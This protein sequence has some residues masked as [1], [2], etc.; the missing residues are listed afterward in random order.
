M[1]TLCIELLCLSALVAKNAVSS[2]PLV[3]EVADG[4]FFPAVVADF[5]SSNTHLRSHVCIRN[6][7]YAMYL[8]EIINPAMWCGTNDRFGIVFQYCSNE[9]MIQ[10]P[11]S[12]SLTHGIH[13]IV[14]LIA[15]ACWDCSS[16]SSQSSW[17]RSPVHW[18]PLTEHIRLVYQWDDTI[19]SAVMQ[20]Q[21]S[22]P[23]WQCGISSLTN[24]CGQRTPI[25]F[26]IVSFGICIKR[27][28]SSLL[29]QS[30]ELSY[31]TALHLPYVSAVSKMHGT[32][33]GN[34]E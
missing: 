4:F 9:S 3:D 30:V 5:H 12:L 17:F 6:H 2:L 1:G 32:S 7:G 16:R 33:N 31:H 22:I 10:L 19:I 29:L 25:L 24:R 21:K 15:I 18:I 20:I 26:A 11:I 13:S 14:L 34:H 8:Q 27:I 23:F 28:E